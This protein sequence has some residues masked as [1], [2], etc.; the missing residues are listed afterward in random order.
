MKESQATEFSRNYLR[1]NALLAETTGGNAMRE[2]EGY[3]TCA[4]ATA[5]GFAQ[6]Y[7]AKI[8]AHQDKSES[9]SV[10]DLDAAA[11]CESLPARLRGL[12]EKPD[13]NS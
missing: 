3:V 7:R 1:P 5:N 4:V 11:L 9:S 8:V 2:R 10:M 13:A 12:P 6:T